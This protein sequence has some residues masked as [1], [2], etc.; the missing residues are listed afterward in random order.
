MKRNIIGFFSGVA[1]GVATAIPGI[2][3]GSVL[4]ICGSYET[5]CKALSLDIKT[6]K[7]NLFFLAVFAAGAAAG[8]VGLAHAIAYLLL[9]FQFATYMAIAVLICAGLPSVMKTGFKDRPVSPICLI[10]ALLGYAAVITI[11]IFESLGLSGVGGEINLFALIACS[12]MAGITAII[13]GVSGAFV[14]M[15]FGIYETTVAAVVN[16]DFGVIIPIGIG[17]LAGL[18]GGSRLITAL[19]KRA[20]QYVYSAIIGMI[21]GSALMLVISSLAQ[22]G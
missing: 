18:I 20:R 17:M 12:A 4:V 6:I 19:L 21:I 7:E 5:V 1:Y 10:P 15:V 2:S 22:Y 8:L 13:P 14:L 3:G 9:H 16:L 11:F